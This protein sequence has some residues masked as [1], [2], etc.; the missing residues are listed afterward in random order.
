MS[1]RPPEGSITRRALLWTGALGAAGAVAARLFGR[2]STE[3]AR[4][5]CDTTPAQTAGPFYPS[6]DQ[7]DEDLDLTTIQGHAQ[8]AQG[9]VIL[10]RGRILDADC[11]PVPDAL[12]EIWQANTHGRYHHERDTSPAPRDEHFQGWGEVV[13]NSR[14]EYGFKT[15]L[16]GAY[17]A[18]D[19]Q[20]TRHIHFRVARRGYHELITQMYFEGEPLNGQDV[21]L[22]ELAPEEQARV[23]VKKETVR[24]GEPCLCRFDVVLT[25]V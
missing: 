1:S 6:E 7:A 21:V 23:I 11:Q 14:G 12:V 2:A 15:I 22:N 16:P 18:G 8:S 25:K 19:I 3:E 20:R 13:T 24:E 10:V 17:G 9:E 5:A 4:A